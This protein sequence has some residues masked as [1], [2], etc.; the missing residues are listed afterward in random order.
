MPTFQKYTHWL[1]GHKYLTLF[2]VYGVSSTFLWPLLLLPVI[3][4]PT[5]TSLLAII[6]YCL[7]TY[8]VG[9]GGRPERRFGRVWWALN[10]FWPVCHSYFPVSLRVW[11]GS[12]FAAAPNRRHLRALPQRAILAM[13]PHGPFP[14]SASLIM[15]QLARFGAGLD[16]CFE[17]VRFAAA[18]AVFWLWLVRDMY[19]WLG[20]I[21]A[22]RTVLT[23]VST[24]VGSSVR[25]SVRRQIGRFV[26]T[27]VVP[28]AGPLLFEDW[29]WRLVL[30]ARCSPRALPWL[31]EEPPSIPES[32]PGTK[33]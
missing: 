9:R 24:P 1:D 31:R 2:I 33:R 18:S 16:G 23:R 30:R 6:G 25:P 22:S 7:Y 28:K 29:R 8:G 19:L 27:A 26:A 12:S 3:W 32:I 13:H 15:P 5:E 17:N 14:L 21:E 10:K 20:C 4:R 11:D